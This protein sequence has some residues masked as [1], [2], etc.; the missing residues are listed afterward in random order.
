VAC[1]DSVTAKSWAEAAKQAKNKKFYLLLLLLL[2][3][4]I[5]KTNCK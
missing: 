5:T 1:L 2:E 4:G 3:T